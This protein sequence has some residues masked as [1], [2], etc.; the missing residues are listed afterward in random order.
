MKRTLT[1][2]TLALGLAT[3][4]QAAA[5]YKT[6]QPFYYVED[7]N[8]YANMNLTQAQRDASQL[9]LLPQFECPPNASCDDFVWVLIYPTT[10]QDASMRNCGKVPGYTGGTQSSH[11]P[12]GF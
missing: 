10:A 11:G 2:L 6:C 9:V 5:T 4:A 3:T 7:A 1:I 8:T 12:F